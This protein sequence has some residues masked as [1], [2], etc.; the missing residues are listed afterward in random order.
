MIIYKITNE[1]NDKIYIGQTTQSLNDRIKNYWDEVV[2]SKTSRPI[3][4]A[5]R[6]YGYNKFHFEIVEDNINSK[7]ELDQKEIYYIKFF[8]SLTKENGYN[9]ENGG[10]SVGKHSEE[11]KYKISQAQLGPLNH[12]Y[13]KVGK[14]NST[15]K[16][17]IELTTGKTY[18]SAMLATKE[19][20]L[21][22][23]HICAVARG[24]RGSTGGYVFRYLD[25]NNQP[26]RPQ[27]VAY[28]KSLKTQ[29]N[30]LPQYKYLISSQYRAKP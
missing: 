26:I 30:I 6:K 12:M 13:G 15:S 24:T 2:Y 28:I 14:L 8:H 22:F 25:E 21:N 7:E 27:T 23:S 20:K 9:I 16:P 18:E 17:V 10:N 19:L 1:I 4:E 3:I 5:M 29:N 11:T